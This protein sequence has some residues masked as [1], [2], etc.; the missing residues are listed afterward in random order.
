MQVTVQRVQHFDPVHEPHLRAVWTW[1]CLL[2]GAGVVTAVVCVLCAVVFDLT[3]HLGW[4]VLSNQACIIFMRLLAGFYDSR[5][6]AAVGKIKADQHKVVAIAIIIVS[7]SSSHFMTSSRLGLS[8]S[9][10]SRLECSYGGSESHSRRQ[11]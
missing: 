7:S 4:T 11:V 3:A 6:L 1:M 8:V 10:P 5:I 9:L 2:S